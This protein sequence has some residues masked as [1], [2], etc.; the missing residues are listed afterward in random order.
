MR[1]GALQGE[2]RRDTGRRKRH[3]AGES[4]RLAQIYLWTMDEYCAWATIKPLRRISA[5]ARGP[6]P[7]SCADERGRD[8]RRDQGGTR[9]PARSQTR[10]G[11]SLGWGLAYVCAHAG[12][13]AQALGNQPR[14]EPVQPL[15]QEALETL[16]PARRHQRHHRR[17]RPLIDNISSAAVARGL[18]R[19]HRIFARSGVARCMR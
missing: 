3:C 4:A 11:E 8:S 2:T 6:M 16:A 19:V 9:R 1:L 15:K 14:G 7:R 10:I 12:G 17:R 18:C 13:P 5:Q